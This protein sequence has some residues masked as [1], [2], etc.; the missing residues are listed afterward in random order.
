M[1]FAPLATL[2][3]CYQMANAFW[4]RT[5]TFP[6]ANSQTHKENASNATIAITYQRISALQFPFC[7][8]LI[9]KQQE[10]VSPVLQDT[11]SKTNNAFTLLW[12]SILGALSTPT[13]IAPNASPVSTFKVSSA[14]K[15]IPDVWILTTLKT[16][17]QSVSTR[18]PKD[19][20]VPDS[21]TMIL[22]NYF[23]TLFY[24]F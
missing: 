22:I 2:D 10:N 14:G 11:F 9:I 7:A 13:H 20:P 1:V 5:C 16:Y 15:S 17:V 23:S 21:C 12:E 18:I 19:L 3:M 8:T 24:L 6:S 4:V